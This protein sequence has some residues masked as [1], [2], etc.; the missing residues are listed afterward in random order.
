MPLVRRLRGG[1]DLRPD[2]V[3]AVPEGHEHIGCKVLHRLPGFVCLGAW[4]SIS[5]SVRWKIKSKCPTLA[6]RRSSV[7]L[8]PTSWCWCSSSELPAEMTN[9]V[10]QQ[11]ECQGATVLDRPTL[12]VPASHSAPPPS[13][14]HQA[15]ILKSNY[16][17]NYTF[18]T[19]AERTVAHHG[20]YWGK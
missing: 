15:A 12:E 9:C 16:K 6:L 18:C 5:V 14:S 17:A 8:S 10:C 7:R 19:G 20:T 11:S 2:R 1:Q 13:L 4:Y 3:P